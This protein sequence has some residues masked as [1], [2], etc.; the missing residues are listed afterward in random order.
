ML[1]T[2]LV[3]LL[4]ASSGTPPHEFTITAYGAKPDGTT[5]NRYAIGRAVA[6]AAA[7]ASATGG[8]GSAGR[9]AHVVVPAGG[10]FL[11]G[12]ISL[13]TRVYLKLDTG[14]LLLGSAAQDGYPAAGWNWDPALI[15]THNASFTG[16]IGSGTIDGESAHPARIP[17]FY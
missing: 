16:V 9:F 5:D 14:A 8:G 17:P 10:S 11:T 6:A 3:V 7:W 15:D 1:A 4:A 12:S 2:A 13:A